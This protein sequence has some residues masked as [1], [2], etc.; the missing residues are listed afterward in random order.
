MKTSYPNFEKPDKEVQRIINNQDQHPK[1]EE[2]L[3]TLH[4]EYQI[5]IEKTL[6]HYVSSHDLPDIPTSQIKI[7][8]Y[9]DINKMIEEVYTKAYEVLKNDLKE[10]DTEKEEESSQ[11]ILTLEILS[12][13]F[14][15]FVKSFLIQKLEAES[16]DTDESVAEIMLMSIVISIDFLKNKNPDCEI[17]LRLL[18]NQYQLTELKYFI[19]TRAM[20]EKE[21]NKSF[22]HLDIRERIDASGTVLNI[23]NINSLMETMFGIGNRKRVKNFLDKLT[24]LDEDFCYKKKIKIHKF[25]YIA[26]YD[27]CSYSDDFVKEFENIENAGK[28]RLFNELY[29][30][31][32]ATK[33][34]YAQNPKVYN[35]G[36]SNYIQK[37]NK[38]LKDETKQ[39]TRKHKT[40]SEL[41]PKRNLYQDFNSLCKENIDDVTAMYST[42]VR[43]QNMEKKRC[44]ITGSKTLNHKTIT[45]GKKPKEPLPSTPK[46]CLDSNLSRSKNLSKIDSETW[47][48]SDRLSDKS[49]ANSSKKDFQQKQDID[50]IPES[51]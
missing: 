4:E 31:I 39:A 51:V 22:Y 10:Q 12:D 37:F 38:G 36:A 24:S 50:A 14:Y 18:I 46:K 28:N 23:Y 7:L 42:T 8:A 1:R 21:L 2:P 16:E 29:Q 43:F 45:G 15:Q 19:F 13:S 27:F 6:Q 32:H 49:V 30:P 34:S 25:L 41:N 20:I 11:P 5:K 33:K 9:K 26:L 44:K 17:F 48:Y 47:K 3:P 40:M 35:K